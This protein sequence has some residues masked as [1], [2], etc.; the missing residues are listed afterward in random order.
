M[1][2]VP[3]VNE[4]Y[5]YNIQHAIIYCQYQFTADLQCVCSLN[6]SI[7]SVQYAS[8]LVPPKG[9]NTSS[10]NALWSHRHHAV[11]NNKAQERNQEQRLNALEA[12]SVS[13]SLL[14]PNHF[15]AKTHSS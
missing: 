10:Q 13:M 14:F 8:V 12:A 15:E 7:A 11:G 1:H 9:N 4:E 6:I 5:S 2:G 3:I